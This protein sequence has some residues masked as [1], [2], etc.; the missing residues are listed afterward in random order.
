[1]NLVGG[2]FLFHLLLLNSYC[3]SQSSCEYYYEFLGP[4]GCEWCGGF[5]TIDGNGDEVCHQCP[6]DTM[7]LGGGSIMSCVCFGG[8]KTIHVGNSIV[9]EDCGINTRNNLNRSL[10]VPCAET[11]DVNPYWGCTCK[12]GEEGR[13]AGGCRPCDLNYY[14]INSGNRACDACSTGKF[15]HENR[16]EC[17]MCPEDTTTN[18]TTGNCVAHGSCDSMK[19]STEVEIPGYAYLSHKTLIGSLWL[20]EALLATLTQRQRVEKCA[21]FCD[22]TPT[23]RIFQL[24]VRW[25]T[26][27][28][29]LLNPDSV[30]VSA[31][32]QETYATDANNFP[33]Q[34]SFAVYKRCSMTCPLGSVYY[35]DSKS[36]V[37]CAAGKFSS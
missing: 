24:T 30:F 34:V 14:S 17:L 4:G 33:L 16:L 8:K 28:C 31:A 26:V 15:G 29:Q 6:D 7:G 3:N 13:H 10:C 12:A 37:T 27:R 36:C 9:C 32:N 20:N 18:D 22:R 25:G 23:C 35:H 11:L 2:T 21:A 1:M 19:V 5:V